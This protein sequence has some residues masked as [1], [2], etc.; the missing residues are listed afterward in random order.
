MFATVRHG[1][2]GSSVPL[3]IHCRKFKQEN[4]IVKVDNNNEAASRIAPSGRRGR[5]GSVVILA[6]SVLIGMLA[7][8][9]A[10]EP[11]PSGG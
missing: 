11:K 1:L 10:D 5:R 2:K 9:M 8:V 4:E 7:P 6:A 3:H